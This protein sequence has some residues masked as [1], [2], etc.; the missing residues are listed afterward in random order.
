MRNLSK[1]YQQ[2]DHI[3]NVNAGD[4]KDPYSADTTGIQVSHDGLSMRLEFGR[5]DGD[6]MLAT[7]ALETSAMERLAH[8][9]LKCVAHAREVVKERGN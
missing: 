4:P 7:L 8:E 1:G 2:E 9:I 3:A 6:K 5:Q